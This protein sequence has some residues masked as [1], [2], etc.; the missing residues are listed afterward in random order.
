VTGLRVDQIGIVVAD[1]EAAM[2]GYV[3]TFGTAFYVFE[4]DE[5][6]ARFS[7]S[8]ATFRTRFALGQAGG[9]SIELIQ[10]RA[11]T[12][13]HST[14]LERHGPGLHHLGSYT[15]SLGASAAQLDRRGYA[16]L[17]DGAIPGL[18]E[19]AYYQAPDL[20]AIVEPLQ[21]SPRMPLF[22]ARHA[23]RYRG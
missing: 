10:P 2:D 4:V 13:I 20:C 5:T 18:A 1:L 8:S 6:M 9:T 15:L 3:A 14:F 21:L 11:G 22:L 23:R 12:T 16:R 19:F 7:G 17:M